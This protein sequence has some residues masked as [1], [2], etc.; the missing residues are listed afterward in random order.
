MGVEGD[1]GCCKGIYQN[2]GHTRKLTSSSSA[3]LDYL[4]PSLNFPVGFLLWE[5]WNPA[6][7]GRGWGMPNKTQ[8]CSNLL[9]ILLRL[10]CATLEGC[11][12]GSQTE[13]SGT[14]D[15][16]SQWCHVSSMMQV[17][18]TFLASTE[19]CQ[20]PLGEEALCLQPRGLVWYW[21]LILLLVQD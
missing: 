4:V 17:T 15:F 10:C 12:H 8:T 20:F 7:W 9:D 11:G 14:W 1:L 6:V 16:P 21:L 3:L 19:P 13:C 18:G 2:P 5:S